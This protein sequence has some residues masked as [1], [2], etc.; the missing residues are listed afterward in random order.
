MRRD[1]N[2][3]L[4][5]TF[6]AT[7]VIG[8]FAIGQITQISEKEKTIIQESLD[9]MSYVNAAHATEK[10]MKEIISE[11]DLPVDIKTYIAKHFSDSKIIKAE[12]EKAMN[13]IKHEVKLDSGVELE[14]N[15]KNEIVEID[16]TSKLP[17]TVIP[18]SILKYVKTNYPDNAITDW[19]L[20]S[21]KQEVKL[22]NGIELEFNLAGKFLRVDK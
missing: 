20:K 9:D 14:F 2:N 10:N 15:G 3:F 12:R 4:I 18:K 11:A 17:E 7:F 6:I 21:V 5:A 16:G 19:E 1:L 22:D 8:G 13:G